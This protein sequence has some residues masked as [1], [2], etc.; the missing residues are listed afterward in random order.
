RYV[1]LKAPPKTSLSKEGAAMAVKKIAS[2]LKDELVVFKKPSPAF[3]ASLAELI[4]QLKSAKVTPASLS[5]AASG[6]ADNLGAKLHDISLVYAGYEKFLAENSLTD[7]NDSLGVMSRLLRSDEKIK[8]SHVIVAG[9]SSVTKQIC[10]ILSELFSV[11]KKCDFLCLGGENKEVYTEEVLD[12]VKTVDRTPPVYENSSMT[13]E[14]RLL[15]GRLFDPVTLSKAGL[16]SDKITFYEAEDPEDEIENIAKQ[17]RFGVIRGARYRDFAVGLGSL[18]EYSVTLR[19]VFGDYNIPFFADEKR[20]LSEHPAVKLLRDALRAY[21]RGGNIDDIKN[22]ISN[23]AFIPDKAVSDDMLRRIVTGVIGGKEFLRS[24]EVIFDDLY[25]SSKREAIRRLFGVLSKKARAGEYVSAAKKFLEEAFV[26]DNVSLL[27]EK[28][29]AAEDAE[30][31]SF[32]D[33]AYAKLLS[34]LDE[35]DKVIGEENVS[36]DEFIKIMLSGADACEI[37]LIPQYN[38]V[39]YVGELKDCR[40]KKHD[41]LFA[42]GLGGD[43]PSIKADVALLHDGDINKL[44]ALS[45]KVEPKIRVV[46]RRER[47]AVALAMLAFGQSLRC[48]YSVSSASGRGLVK[49]DLL[50]YVV[51]SFSGDGA[52]GKRLVPYRKISFTAAAAASDG[53]RKDDLQAYDYLAP[54]PAL[55][56]LAKQADDFRNGGSNDLEVCSSFYAA[57]KR[58]GHEKH[59]AAADGLLENKNASVRLTR[60]LPNE[61]FF[62]SKTVSASVLETYYS[63]PYQNYLKYGLGLSDD[64]S[65]EATPLDFGNILHA[66]AEKFICRRGEIGEGSTVEKLAGEIFDEILCGAEFEKF[67]KRA[68]LGFSSGLLKEEGIRL[69]KRL[70]AETLRSDFSPV[71]TEV[72]FADWAEH[73]ALPLRTK[74]AGYKL[75]GKVD[76]LDEYGDYVRIIDYKTGGAGKKVSDENFYTGRNIQLYLYMN[77]FARGKKIGGAYYYS[78]EDGYHAEDAE[79]VSMYGMTLADEKVVAATDKDL[80]KN[81]D[82]DIIEAKKKDGEEE[83]KGNFVDER[84]LRGYTAYARLLAEKC[85]D[86]VNEGVTVASP[87]GDACKYCGYAAVCGYDGETDGRTRKVKAI[88]PETIVSAAEAENGAK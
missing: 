75:C 17:I 28:F 59:L 42:A 4:A 16:Y 88:R 10:D 2:S 73:K 24:E 8:R 57:L 74:T 34:L 3:A 29:S 60:V 39:V 80:A 6:R 21:V 1:R 33:A 79:R 11:S 77:A 58:G 43:V 71:A 31:K 35:I 47:E 19:K 52:S 50:E 30:V 76:R 46:N 22:I 84:T 56:S 54:R 64:V 23:S 25:E 37:S 69:C 53:E 86:R 40:I 13:D 55:F 61:N 48:S 68:D 65:S 27:S 12:F 7:N 26:K 85:V 72:W 45:V 49:S 62:P 87:Y 44:E 66:L 9:L 67:S 70:Y 51:S 81:G 36:A 14:A 15:A 41:V 78:L 18:G 32:N 20:L 38:D 83:Y 82:S 63:C 5:E